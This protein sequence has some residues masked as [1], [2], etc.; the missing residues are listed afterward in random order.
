SFVLVVV[1]SVL[2]TEVGALASPASAGMFDL[3][4]LSPFLAGALQALFL[5]VMV[6]ATH[7]IGAAFGGGGSF[8]DSLKLTVWLQA[9]LVGMQA[10]QLAAFLL[11]PALAALLGI[12]AL[13]WFFWVL[14]HF[15]MVLHGFESRSKVF[16]GILVSFVA[17]VF[18]LSL[19]L[20][21]LGLVV[22]PGGMQ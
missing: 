8:E 14:T 6:H 12:A 18:G 3:L 2:L 15:V 13:A 10:V 11:V 21:M 20:A 16:L 4:R 17:L 22:V 7:R 19:L 1:L 9:M 5:F